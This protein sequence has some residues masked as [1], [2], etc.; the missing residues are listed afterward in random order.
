MEELSPKRSIGTGQTVY[1]VESCRRVRAAVVRSRSGALY[2]VRFA[3]T[4]GGI[5]LRGDRLY[6][7]RAAA[8]ASLRQR[9][10]RPQMIQPA[11]NL[12]HNVPLWQ[13]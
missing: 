11:A 6:P 2:T 4:G 9:M 12:W 7:S 13:C 8:E 3:D 5:R 10:Q 1:L